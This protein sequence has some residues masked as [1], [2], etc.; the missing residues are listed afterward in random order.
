[1]DSSL[2]AEIKNIYGID[3]SDYY[4]EKNSHNPLVYIHKKYLTKN[5]AGPYLER[6]NTNQNI[7][8]KCQQF[9]YDRLH[10]ETHKTKVITSEYKDP[11]VDQTIKFA[12]DIIPITIPPSTNLAKPCCYAVK[13]CKKIKRKHEPQEYTSNIKQP[14]D[15]KFDKEKSKLTLNLKQRKCNKN[16][17]SLSTTSATHFSENNTIDDI[18]E[19]QSLSYSLSE[20]SEEKPIKEVCIEKNNKNN[21]QNPKLVASESFEAIAAEYMNASAESKIKIHL[22]NEKDKLL[23]C[24]NIRSPVLK[25]IKECYELNNQNHLNSEIKN[26]NKTIQCHATK[27]DNILEKLACIENKLDLLVKPKESLKIEVIK[28][29]KLEELGQDI[30]GF[31]EESSEEELACVNFSTKSRSK[32]TPV[33]PMYNEKDAERDYQSVDDL[34]RGENVPEYFKP[35]TSQLGIMPE[36]SNR[37]PARFCWTDT[38]MK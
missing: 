18:N 38:V 22:M 28:A 7:N 8:D 35:S 24:E 13:S 31:K 26:V 36:R 32:H 21:L 15:A 12:K 19:N 30:G 16:K 20:L 14:I 23:F 11:L 27:I 25:A 1:M 33:S 3:L 10:T 2:Y 17:D 34:A 6:R 29:S 9:D 4:V 37:I 5:D